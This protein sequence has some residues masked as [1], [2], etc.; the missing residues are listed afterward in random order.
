MNRIADFI[1]E[2]PFPRKWEDAD[3]V[4]KPGYLG[5][6]ISTIKIFSNARPHMAAFVSASLVFI[7][8][9]IPIWFSVD[10]AS[11]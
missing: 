1:F 3:W 2:G 11:N 5:N 4:D 8:C 6:K 7:F 9:G 10:A